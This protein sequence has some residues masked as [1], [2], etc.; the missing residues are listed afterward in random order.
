MRTV[1]EAQGTKGHRHKSRTIIIV[2]LC[3][4]RVP[5]GLKSAFRAGLWPDC[6]REST[7]I[8][9]PAVPRPAGGRILG[10]S[11]LN[12]W[13]PG[14]LIFMIVL[15]RSWDSDRARSTRY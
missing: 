10:V 9:H 7:E 2:T 8:G 1:P 12:V 13:V 3:D 5:P 11:R 4:A 6:Y 15:I 14:E